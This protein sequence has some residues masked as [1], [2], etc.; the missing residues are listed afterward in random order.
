LPEGAKLRFFGEGSYPVN[1][2]STRKKALKLDLSVKAGKPG[3]KGIKV[4]NLSEV[5]LG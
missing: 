5:K 3:G 4:A 1:W 2:V